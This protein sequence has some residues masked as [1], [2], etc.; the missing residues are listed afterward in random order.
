M[1]SHY[2]SGYSMKSSAPKSGMKKKKK[3]K[4]ATKAGMR[5]KKM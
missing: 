2:G 3:K 1:P 4:T 5:K